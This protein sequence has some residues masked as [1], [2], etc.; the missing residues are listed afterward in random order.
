[1]L[2]PKPEV[3]M[4]DVERLLAYIRK[5]IPDLDK[6]SSDAAYKYASLPLCI[7]DA[8]F[9]IGVRYGST[10]AVV[11][12]WCK[13]YDWEQ[14]RKEGIPHHTVSEFLELLRPYHNRWEQMATEIFGNRQRTSSRSGIL[15]AEAVFKFAKTLHSF[16]IESFEDALKAAS[17]KDVRQ[18]IESIPG[19]H[20]GISYDY[21]LMLVGDTNGVKADRMVRGFVAYALGLRSVSKEM[22]VALVQQA[23]AL[24]RPEHPILTPSLLDNAIWHYER[25]KQD[26]S[27]SSCRAMVAS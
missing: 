27:N 18:G 23:A 21:F 13:R 17:R 19:Q 3:H 12:R 8:V 6:P 7:I 4:S 25:K 9:S 10:M 14:E 1:M 2:P 22:C 16:G 20:S 26:A 15:K 5:T 11:E 24:L